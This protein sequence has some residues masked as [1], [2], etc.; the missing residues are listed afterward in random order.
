MSYSDTDT[1]FQVKEEKVYVEPAT[2][3]QTK[4]IFIFIR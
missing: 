2:I 4:F 1:N 3:Q